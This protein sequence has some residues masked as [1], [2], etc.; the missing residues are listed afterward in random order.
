MKRIAIFLIILAFVVPAVCLVAAD[1][2]ENEYDEDLYGPEAPVIWEKP[3]RGVIFS[4]KRHTME[5]GLDCDECHDELFEMEA[6]AAEEYEDFNMEAMYDGKYCG[7]CHD[8]DYAFAANTR[9]TTCHIGVRGVERLTGE[10]S[11]ES[12]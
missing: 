5:F 9:C 2:D 4:H 7:A 8:G 12:H 11:E 3:V 1:N 10:S 6:G